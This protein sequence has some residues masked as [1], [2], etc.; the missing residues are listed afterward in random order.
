MIDF[1]FI[2]SQ[3]YRRSPTAE[4]VARSLGYRAISAGTDRDAIRT[5]TAR[6]IERV[7]RI[8]CMEECHR[9]RLGIMIRDRA[10]LRR[11]EAWDIPDDYE[12]CHP[13]LIDII[14]LKLGVKPKG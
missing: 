13:E 4:H 8:V 11:I 5:V 1:L 10:L 12:Y 7:D 9:M 2:C 3:N 6:D 14:R